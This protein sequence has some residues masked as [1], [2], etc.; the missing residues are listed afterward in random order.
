MKKLQT[1]TSLITKILK[2]FNMNK[3]LKIIPPEGYEIDKENS[4]LEVIKFKLIKKAKTYFDVAKSLFEG[5]RSWFFT[6]WGSVTSTIPC[7]YRDAN[8]CTSEEQAQKLLDINKL[9]NVAKYLNKGWKPDFKNSSQ[10]KYNLG[11]ANDHILIDCTYGYNKCFVY[12]KTRELAE[13]AIEILGE[14]TIKNIFSND[15]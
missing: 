3:E 9:M 5:K 15:W 7:T 12:F 10:L 6:G 4:T 13:Q 14:E 8:L 2:K 11:V 1:V